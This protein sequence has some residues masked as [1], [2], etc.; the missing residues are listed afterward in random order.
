MENLEFTLPSG[1]TAT[2]R[3]QNGE[4]DSIVTNVKLQTEGDA[5]NRFVEAIAISIDGKKPTYNDILN[6]RLSDKYCIVI[7]SRIFSL[8]AIMKFEY[9]WP[10]GSKVTYEEDLSRFIW[11]YSKPFPSN[12]KDPDYDKC[13]IK[14]FPAEEADKFDY[15]FLYFELAGKLFRM[16]FSDGVF[17]KNLIKVGQEKLSNNEIF[18]ARELSQFLNEEWVRVD[19]F[20][21]FT[22]LEMTKLRAILHEYDDSEG[23]TVE[24]PNPAD[25][26]DIVELP[27]MSIP[28]FLAPR[29]I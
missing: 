19:S 15:N 9:Q 25:S 14:P 17:E 23:L 5:Y 27:L 22:P 21:A 13:R 16:R 2:I 11:D 7:Q 6:L 3:M 26:D 20:R 1:K 12:P 8:G 28:D 29:V 24:I 4:D 10:K 18:K